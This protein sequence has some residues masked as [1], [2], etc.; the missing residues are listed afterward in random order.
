MKVLLC[1]AYK[2]RGTLQYF[3]RAFSKCA[4]LTYC[5]LPYGPTR[6]G[7]AADEDLS[8]FASQGSWDLFFYVE[9]WQPVF[10]R[11]IEKLPF[12]TAAFLTDLP[13]DL[14]R[15]LLIAP[16]FD[17]LF[18]AH[19]KYVGIFQKVHPNVFWLPFACDPEVHKRY[20]EEEKIYEVAYVGGTAG[21]RGR[22]LAELAKWFRMNDFRKPC[23]PEGMAKTYSRA[24]VVFNKSDRGEVNM[25]P[26]EALS[27]GPLL[28]TERNSE[29]LEEV[30]QDRKHCV[31]YDRPA[32]VFEV[33][34]YFLEHEEERRQIADAG[35]EWCVA[36]HTYVDR[37]RSIFEVLRESGCRL[38]APA[39]RYSEEE[40]LLAYARVYCNFIMLDTQRMLIVRSQEASATK[41]KA[42]GYLI[43]TMARALRRMGW[44]NWFKHLVGRGIA[45]FE[46]D[47]RDARSRGSGG[48][49]ESFEQVI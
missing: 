25:R 23:D 43:W 30:F 42:L 11:G 21:E 2:P 37:I 13:Y 1:G 45:R 4:S 29:G 7:C 20:A 3:E 34:R 36:N 47:E 28:V 31:F 19:R 40:L 9:E 32:Q 26:F 22:L 16:F 8:A 44:R 12:P 33:I 27:C 6:P 18:L 39:R 17:Y 49:V 38:K 5:G 10:P 15:R 46:H 41:I 35:H 48:K 14:R 24:K